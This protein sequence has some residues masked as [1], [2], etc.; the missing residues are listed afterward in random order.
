[1]IEVT[2]SMQILTKRSYFPVHHDIEEKQIKSFNIYRL[3]GVI[4]VSTLQ[5][6]LVETEHLTGL[7]KM[8]D[9]LVA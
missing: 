6:L 9:W 7:S 3:T 5:H 1:M 4:S 8:V 2:F